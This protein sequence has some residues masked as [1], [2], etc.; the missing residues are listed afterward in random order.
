MSSQGDRK[1]AMRQNGRLVPGEE[2]RIGHY[3]DADGEERDV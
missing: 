1:I 2:Y 3:P